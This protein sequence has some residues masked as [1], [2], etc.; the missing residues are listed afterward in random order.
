[1]LIR[2]KMVWW[3]PVAIR[4]RS[5]VRRRWPV[6]ALAAEGWGLVIRRKMA[7]RWPVAVR[8]DSVLCGCAVPLLTRIV[9]VFCRLLDSHSAH[10]AR[11]SS[12]CSDND[13]LFIDY[14]QRLKHSFGIQSPQAH[15]RCLH[16]GTT[17]D[18]SSV[19]RN[20]ALRSK[21][22]R[23]LMRTPFLYSCRGRRTPY[24][25]ATRIGKDQDCQRYS[26]KMSQ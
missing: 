4:A 20:G 13:V 16:C 7:W 10:F 18:P 21:K 1:M 19:S 24:R 9:S 25:K 3:W 14:L 8:C 11:H 23:R 17:E 5:E 26:K 12:D 2:C 6:T 22:V 15:F